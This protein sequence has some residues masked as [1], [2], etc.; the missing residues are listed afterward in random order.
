MKEYQLSVDLRR[1]W[2]LLAIVELPKETV[3]IYNNLYAKGLCDDSD[4]K[5]IET[6]TAD[7]NWTGCLR[8]D[9]DRVLE[10]CGKSRWISMSS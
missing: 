1:L 9:S 7:G 2:L 8:E 6:I 4:G 10:K 3:I 5:T